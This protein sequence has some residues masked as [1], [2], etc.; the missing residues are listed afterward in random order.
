MPAESTAQQ[1]SLILSTMHRLAAL[2]PAPVSTSVIAQHAGMEPA[3][4]E[5][6]LRSMARVGLV[7]QARNGTL[8]VWRLD[9]EP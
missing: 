4:V 9:R 7:Q 1:W 2:N 6:H 5:R 3:L 8:G